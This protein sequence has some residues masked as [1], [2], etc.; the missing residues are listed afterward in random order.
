VIKVTFNH[1]HL[2]LFNNNTNNVFF[3][4][5]IIDLIA[6][7]TRRA[8]HEVFYDIN[9]PIDFESKLRFPDVLKYR[10]NWFLYNS[11]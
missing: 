3:N 9:I 7:L 8:Y 6:I 10:C 4:S 5:D 2:W 1:L 11:R